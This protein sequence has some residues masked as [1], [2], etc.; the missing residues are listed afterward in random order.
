VDDIGAI[1]G[2][3]VAYFVY[4]QHVQLRQPQRK[5]SADTTV[6]QPDYQV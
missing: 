1:I 2:S 6:P 3:G 5:L 4:R